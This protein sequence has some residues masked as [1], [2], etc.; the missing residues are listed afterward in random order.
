MSKQDHKIIGKNI[1]LRLA[2]LDDA[3]FI[4]DLRLKKGQFLSPSSTDV[5]MQEQWL[6]AYF[7]RQKQGLEYYFIISNNDNNN[8]I[9]TAR[10]YNINH[11]EKSFVFGSF[12]VDKD[13]A[14]LR[15]ASFEAMNLTLGFTFNQ[16]KLE[17]CRFDCRKNND[18]ANNFYRRFG[19][20]LTGETELDYLYQI[21]NKN[22]NATNSVS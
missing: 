5:K 18:I 1:N 11:Q 20:V 17:I 6:E 3:S 14:S 8:K 7:T 13:L 9:G 2:C 15:S 10:I 19:A 12:I 21:I 22:Y 4:V 16:L